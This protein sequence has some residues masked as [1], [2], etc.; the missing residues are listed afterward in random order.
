[1]LEKIINLDKELFVF[2]N[3]LGSK[4]FD[5]LWLIITEQRNWIPF[6]IILIYLVYNKLGTKKTAKVILAVAVLILISDQ[7]CNLF[8]NHFQRLRP[9]NTE[10]LIGLIR[11]IKS[12]DTY[13]FFSGHATNTSA[14]ATFL[15]LILRKRYNHFYLIFLWPLIFAYS[16]IYLGLHFPIDILTGY[17]VGC[18]FGFIGYKFFQN[19]L[20]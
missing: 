20:K 1:M 19:L 7:T 5:G 9:C 10:D 18:L 17:L 6:F 12:S 13:S 15:F 14:I 4:S 2:L 16:R 11:V 3:N 8:K